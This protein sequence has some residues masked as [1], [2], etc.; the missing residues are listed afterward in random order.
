ME[1]ILIIG[2][3]GLGKEVAELIRQINDAKPYK[4]W[5]ILGFLDDDDSKWGW[6]VNGHY[7]IGGLDLLEKEY[8]NVNVVVAIA[9]TYIRRNITLCIKEF[10]EF[11]SLI[12]PNITIPQSTVIGRGTL[13]FEGCVLSTNIVVGEHC[14]LSPMVAIGHETIIHAFST[15][16]WRVTIAGNVCINS[17]CTLG[18]C[19]TIIQNI[20]IV[21][22]IMV[23]AGA[24]VVRDAVVKKS[25][26][27]GIPAKR[28]LKY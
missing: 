22:G 25:T 16:L 6:N 21:E 18:S 19:S 4:R 11:P 20:N 1:N 15:L 14:I 8:K 27:V 7:V 12:H 9:D 17:H 3:G 24:V 26:L 23:G 2:C 28:I 13:I 5:N 10:C